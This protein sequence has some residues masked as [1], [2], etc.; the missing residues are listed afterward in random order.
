MKII[1]PLCGLVP[2]HNVTIYNDGLRKQKSSLSPILPTCNVCVSEVEVKS[3][4]RGVK[5]LLLNGTC[6]SGKSSTA[7]ELV[8]SH[9]FAA[10]D[11]DNAMRIVESKLGERRVGFESPEFLEE[12]TKEIDILSAVGR[13]IVISTV[14]EKEIQQYKNIFESKGM[15]YRIILLK[16][17]Y[18]VAVK[19]TQTRTCF[20]S[21]T[22]EVWVRHFYDALNCEGVDVFDNS[23]LSVE[24]SAV[25]IL[26]L[27][28]GRNF[29]V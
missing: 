10:I 28:F 21:V 25:E 12:I 19:R 9:G 6:G 2:L 13:K 7:E 1:C 20:T 11:G 14:V 26:Q 23:D 18:E 5:I 29:S 3:D 8:K 4:T 17:S 27:A 22:P 16:P 15:D 24:Q